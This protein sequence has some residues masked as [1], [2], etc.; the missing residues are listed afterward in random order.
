VKDADNDVTTE[1][2][3]EESEIDIG[4]SGNFNETAEEQYLNAL[5]DSSKDDAEMGYSAEEFPTPK[6]KS[7]YHVVTLVRTQPICK[8]H[9]VLFDE[10]ISE[11]QQRQCGHSILVEPFHDSNTNPIGIVFK[12]RYLK[13]FFKLNNFIWLNYGVNPHTAAI[14]LKKLSD[15]GVKHIIWIG[16]EA[17]EG[18]ESAR[19]LRA[20]WIC[21]L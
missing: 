17:K 14:H 9:A 13:T 10:V 6:I 21:Y 8:A 11:A 18:T 1:V 15:E 19:K 12:M 4:E 7:E 5:F 3:I 20:S 2:V 16:G